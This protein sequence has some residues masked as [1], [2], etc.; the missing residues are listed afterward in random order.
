MERFSRKREAV[1]PVDKKLS[2]LRMEKNLTKNTLKDDVEDEYNE[3]MEK[4]D[5]LRKKI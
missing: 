5:V 2:M 1:A 4:L 3:N